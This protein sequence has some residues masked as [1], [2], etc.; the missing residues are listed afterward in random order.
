MFEIFAVLSADEDGAVMAA[1]AFESCAALLSSMVI[2]RPRRPGSVGISD[3]DMNL[4]EGFLVDLEKAEVASLKAA[5]A[6]LEVRR[7]LASS[8]EVASR[9]EWLSLE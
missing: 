5:A 3:S 9:P 6:E 2:P 4:V 1:E 7:S 8:N